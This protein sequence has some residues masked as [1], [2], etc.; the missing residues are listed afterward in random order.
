MIETQTLYLVACAPAMESSGKS[1]DSLARIARW[2]GGAYMPR[3]AKIAEA[4]FA[5][6]TEANRK[7]FIA[8]VTGENKA[9]DTCP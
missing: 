9:S 6:A 2:C 8:E 4:S 3:V 7:K 5:F 1:Y